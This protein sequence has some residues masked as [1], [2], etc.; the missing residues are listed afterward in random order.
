MLA[1]N[2]NQKPIGTVDRIAPILISASR[3]VATVPCQNA[4]SIL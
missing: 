4:L 1:K 2:N 3:S